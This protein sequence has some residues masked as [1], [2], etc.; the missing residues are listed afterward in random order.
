MN[1]LPPFR[2][3]I[4]SPGDVRPERIIARRI[5]ERLDRE[6]RYHLRLE[7]ALWERQPLVA[8][9]HFQDGIPR[10][11]STDLVVVVIWSRLGTP[12]PA[13]RFVGPLSGGTVTGTE[14]EFE[15][16]LLASMR[17]NRPDLLVYRKTARAITVLGSEREDEERNQRRAVER[18]FASWFEDSA[19]GSLRAA[20]HPFSSPAEFEEM[21]HAH[22]REWVLRRVGDAGALRSIRWHDGSPFRGLESFEPRHEPVFFGRTRAR[23]EVRQAL[24]AQMERG[25]AMVLILGASGSGK[26]SLLKAGLVPD[27]TTPGML[28]N[29]GRVWWAV[30]RPSDDA[31]P[32]TAL[33]RCIVRA[34]EAP[35]DCDLHDLLASDAGAAAANIAAR[36]QVLAA[37]TLSAP[38]RGQLLIIIDQLEEVFSEAVAAPWRHSFLA[39]LEAL[40]SSGACLLLASMRS[41][42]FRHLETVPGFAA[43]T[44]ENGRYLLTPPSEAEIGQIIQLPAIEAG[45]TF[46]SS[47]ESGIGLDEVLRGQASGSAGILPLLEFTLEQL[48]QR[49]SD[50]GELTYGVYEELGGLTGAIATRAEQVFAAQPAEVQEGLPRLLFML[51]TVGEAREESVLSRPATLALLGQGTPT[52]R[53]AQAFLLPDARLLVAEGSG[54]TATLRVAHEAL[55]GHWPRARDQIAQDRRDLQLRATLERAQLAWD[56][57]AGKNRAS[58]LLP[59]GLPLSQAVDLLH[60][61]HNDLDP[62][63]VRFI[64]ASVDRDKRRIRRLYAMLALFAALAVTATLGAWLGL[65]GQRHAEAS[66]QLAERREQEAERRRKEAERS[67]SLMLAQQA[68]TL[69]ASGRYEAAILASL[70]AL[71]SDLAHPDRPLVM[72]ALRSLRQAV[73][74]DETRPAGAIA[75]GADFIHRPN[76]SGDGRFVASISVDQVDVWDTLRGERT[77]ALKLDDGEYTSEVAFSGSGDTIFLVSGNPSHIVAFDRVSGRPRASLR[78]ATPL[79]QIF[80]LHA[81]FSGDDLLVVAEHFCGVFSVVRQAQ[82]L[83]C[84]NAGAFV[85]G[86]LSPDGR[87]AITLGDPGAMLWDIGRRTVISQ[88]KDGDHIVVSAFSPDGGEFATGSAE[89]RVRT[90]DSGTGAPLADHEAYGGP[91][92]YVEY[93]ANGSLLLSAAYGTI[94]FAERGADLA[95]RFRQD[96]RPG[97]VSPDGS[98]FL[99]L[100]SLYSTVRLRDRGGHLSGEWTASGQEAFFWH[101]ESHLPRPF[102]FRRNGDAGNQEFIDDAF[103]TGD[104]TLI[105]AGTLIQRWRLPSEGT[106]T[107]ISGAPYGAGCV[108]RNGSSLVLFYRSGIAGGIKAQAL[109]LQRPHPAVALEGDVAG[110]DLAAD[111]ILTVDDKGVARLFDC[112]GTIISPRLPDPPRNMSAIYTLLRQ[113]GGSVWFSAQGDALA[114]YQQGDTLVVDLKSGSTKGIRGTIISGDFAAD[115]RFIVLAGNGTITTWEGR[116]RH[117][118]CRLP[119][120]GARPQALAPLSGSPRIAVL[121]EDGEIGLVDAQAC[122]SRTLGKLAKGGESG[123]V[124]ALANDSFIAANGNG[125]GAIWHPSD[126]RP[127]YFPIEGSGEIIA[128]DRANRLVAF[129]GTRPPRLLNL[130]D[131]IPVATLD[132][133]RLPLTSIGFS[134]DGKSLATA[135]SDG[136]VTLWDSRD[137]AKIASVDGFA[138]DPQTVAFAPDGRQ[139]LIT[140]PRKMAALIWWQRSDTEL[141]SFAR[142]RAPG[143]GTGE[144][145]DLGQSHGRAA[146]APNRRRAAP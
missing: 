17:H 88:I 122:H 123:T 37:G 78:T 110:F 60:R 69:I 107:M 77:L 108:G 5:V 65:T 131:G 44:A 87:H 132:G 51:T 136:S 129:N 121:H 85:A 35:D 73:T 137:G 118:A 18:F 82:I 20:F 58:L 117:R 83:D 6:F 55:L 130:A 36:V 112:N 68:Q 128:N 138:G 1:D 76:F 74:Y 39:A 16:A 9:R 45:L 134:P 114:I 19:T 81:D 119:A 43:A 103:F 133:I 13:P 34:L 125:D 30:M 2:V 94:A 54:P 79:G 10:P 27:L 38:W 71:P 120:P 80:S 102:L 28:P 53:L 63:L 46:E 95:A 113:F 75:V 124:V 61:K 109:D 12:L 101:L 106:T 33:A 84:R 146:T 97:A 15:E 135:A 47:R 14:W 144:S 25:R 26:S 99:Q 67:E 24:A 31:N 22:L 11:S 90:W 29:V 59:S 32:V 42:F 23:H 72:E 93:A 41:D 48:W 98:T 127:A 92:G 126:D 64:T 91:V 66:L 49:R 57:E 139:I 143:I 111:R 96:K 56:S 52:A 3:F 140:D 21:L 4:S 89:G 100:P 145:G 62:G 8:T 70:Q 116:D 40:S 142:S 115:G 7:A 104:R 105:T 86:T 141:L 50:K